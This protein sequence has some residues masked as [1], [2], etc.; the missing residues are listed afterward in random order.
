M[1]GWIDEPIVD[2][3]VPERARKRLADAPGP[4]DRDLPL[5]V[6]GLF[7][8]SAVFTGLSGL[9]FTM[10]VYRVDQASAGLTALTVLVAAMIFI[11]LSRPGMGHRRPRPYAGR[12]VVPAELDDAALDLLARARQAVM[13]VTSSRAHRLGLLD[14]VANHVVLPDRLWEI[15]RLAR[16]HTELR[17]EQ[18]QALAEVMTPELAAVLDAQRE[19]LAHSVAAVTERVRELE[20]Y[21]GRVREADAALRA[22]DLRQ[23]NDRYR[24]LLAHTSDTEGL[25]R[26]IDQAD[27]LTRTL[28]E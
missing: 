3:T 27:V 2:P 17:A 5:W 1:G 10:A 22:R 28:R 23:S 12:Y 7:A 21:A 13:A 14:A 20:E 26:L 18:Q 4:P 19:A 24:D 16:V 11:G 9:L 8:V 25:T 6:R 15:A